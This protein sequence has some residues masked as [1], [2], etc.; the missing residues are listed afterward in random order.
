MKISLKLDYPFLKNNEVWFHEPIFICNKRQK[1]L[2]TFECI[3]QG[4]SIY[5]EAFVIPLNVSSVKPATPLMHPKH[6]R[7]HYDCIDF[8]CI[9]MV[10]IY[11]IS[12]I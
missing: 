1:V 8:T 9:K 3:R 4:G 2:Y 12:H 10:Q 5:G 11:I 6:L 7:M